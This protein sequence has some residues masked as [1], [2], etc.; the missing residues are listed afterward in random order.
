MI[1]IFLFCHIGS[2]LVHISGVRFISSCHNHLDIHIFKLLQS[3]RHLFFI[4]RKTCRRTK[5]QIDGIHIQSGTVLKCCQDR[6]PACTTAAVKHLHNNKLCIRRDTYYIACVYFICSRNTSHM[7]TMVMLCCC[8]RYI[9]IHRCIVK[10]KWN[11]G[12]LICSIT[13]RCF[14]CIQRFPYICNLFFCQGRTRQFALRQCL[15]TWMIYHNTSIY[16][17]NPHAFSG[18]SGAVKLCCTD[19]SAGICCL[20]ADLFLCLFLYFVHRRSIN[21]IYPR[22]F[23]D[24]FLVPI[25]GFHRYTSHRHGISIT[26]LKILFFAKLILQ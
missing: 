9:K 26:D 6:C 11:L 18:I 1:R 22:K 24:F 10:H 3:I 5:R 12:I 21:I 13:Q 20:R 19:H 8:V 23:L 17:G 7:G 2:G 15:K 4:I 25:P 16:N 14:S